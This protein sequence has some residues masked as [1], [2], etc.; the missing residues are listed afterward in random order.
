MTVTLTPEQ[1]RWIE[2]AVAAGQFSSIEEAVRVAVADLM[3]G[4]LDDLAW[5]KPYVDDAREDVARGDVM[6]GDEFM[7]WLDDRKANPAN[8]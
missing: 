7:A 2:A 4:D 3:T 1:M 8:R 5:A 6:S